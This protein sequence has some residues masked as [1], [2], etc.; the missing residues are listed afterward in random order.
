[1]SQSKSLEYMHMNIYINTYI[2]IHMYIYTLIYV[3]THIR[4]AYFI[5]YNDP[6][7]KK[8][9]SYTQRH[10]VS[11]YGSYMTLDITLVLV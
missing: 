3:F 11:S 5:F 9:H 6:A 8:I 10:D 7:K 1:M 4:Y 2:Y